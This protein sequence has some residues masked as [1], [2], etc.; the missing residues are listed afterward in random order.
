MRFQ[1]RLKTLLGLVL[2]IALALAFYVW[3]QHVPPWERSGGMIGWSQVAIEE[4]LG[5]PAKVVEGD[6]QDPQA[7]KIGP[8]PPGTYRTLYF[9]GI[10]GQFIVRM[11]AE[12]QGFVCFR[13]L[14]TDKGCYY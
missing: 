12:K 5:P 8:R 9:S 4:R 13:S 11:K 10:D 2:G 14:W 7:Q 1:F 3:S 6:L